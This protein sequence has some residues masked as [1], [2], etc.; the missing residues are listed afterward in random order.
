MPTTQV[1][2]CCDL[3]RA[4]PQVVCVG[5]CNHGGSSE[6]AGH[7]TGLLGSLPRLCG[8]SEEH[9]CSIHHYQS[10][11][12]LLVSILLLGGEATKAHHCCHLRVDAFLGFRLCLFLLLLRWLLLSS[13]LLLVVRLVRLFLLLQPLLVM[14]SPAT[15]TR[16]AR[17]PMGS[18]SQ[19]S[20]QVLTH[21]HT[22]CSTRE[23]V[24]D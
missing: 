21:T 18:H 2:C 5:R 24:G 7:C 10:C 8:S 3:R 23:W 17:T 15:R 1:C 14:C 20:A 22:A 16:T 6:A 4:S 19:G 13:P 11:I 12:V 9:Q